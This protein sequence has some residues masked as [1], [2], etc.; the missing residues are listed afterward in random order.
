MVTLPGFTPAATVIEYAP[1]A[2]STPSVPAEKIAWSPTVYVWVAD[3]PVGS[4]LQFAVVDVSQEPLGAAPPGPGVA[5][6]IS[7]YRVD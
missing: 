4:R 5:P 6:S 1:V 2:L 7:Q 3:A